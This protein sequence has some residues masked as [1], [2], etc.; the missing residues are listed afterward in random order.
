MKKIILAL[1]GAMALVLLASCGTKP[2]PV[3]EKKP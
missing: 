3:E 1:S 2:E